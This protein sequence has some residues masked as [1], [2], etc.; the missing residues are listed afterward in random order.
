MINIRG[1]DKKYKQTCISNLA[2]CCWADDEKRDTRV[3]FG[4]QGGI[5]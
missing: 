3:P 5:L 2:A 1:R 4:R